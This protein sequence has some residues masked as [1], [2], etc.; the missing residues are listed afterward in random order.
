MKIKFDGISG[1]IS[2]YRLRGLK[3]SKKCFFLKQLNLCN[4]IK[5]LKEELKIPDSSDGLIFSNFGIFIG[6][7]IF[8]DS[9]FLQKTYWEQWSSPLE[10]KRTK[11]GP[12]RK[13]RE[14][15][16]QVCS[17]LSSNMLKL[18]HK[19]PRGINQIEKF[20]CWICKPR[21]NQIY[22]LKYIYFLTL[23]FWQTSSVCK[24]LWKSGS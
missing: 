3:I 19:F 4:K 24:N 17:D 18:Y 21:K 15:W 5:V 20:L 22:F 16:T 9:D 7:L 13:S 14:K 2:A 6:M 8:P 1:Q 12:E 23:L 10:H 11:N